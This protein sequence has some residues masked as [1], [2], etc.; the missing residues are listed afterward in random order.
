MSVLT[1]KCPN[2]DAALTFKPEHQNFGCDYCLSSFT[3]AELDQIYHD[4][5]NMQS[6]IEEENEFFVGYRCPSCGAEVM[7]D[8]TTAATFCYY[9]HNPVVMEGRLSGDYKP[10]K[11]IPFTLKKE[12]VTGKFLAWCKK[13][14]FIESSFFSGSQLEKLVGIYYPFWIVDASIHAKMDATGRTLRVWRLGNTEYTETSE[15]ELIRV[16][17][18]DF[19]DIPFAALKREDMNLAKGVYPFDTEN[20]L[21]F[22]MAFLSGFQ[23]EKRDLHKEELTEEAHQLLEKYGES[24]LAD[25]T[26]AYGSV[27]VNHMGINIKKQD[28]SYALLPVWVLTYQFKDKFYYYAMNGQ[29]GKICGEVPVSSRKLFGLFLAVFAVFLIALMIGGWLI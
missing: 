25:T 26:T 19:E 16:G 4:F 10:H 22:S 23:A 24:L 21:D 6:R 28:W 14:W 5:E 27:H 8:D 7:T 29:T 2:C 15:Y 20:M 11:I 3:Q 9:C 1:Y 18:I 12:D 17:D 13:K